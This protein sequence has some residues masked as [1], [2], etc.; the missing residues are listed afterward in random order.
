[1]FGKQG[2]IVR[3]AMI[4]Q[5]SLAA[6]TTGTGKP[7][8]TFSSNATGDS[9]GVRQARRT[10]EMTV[11]RWLKKRLVMLIA[12]YYSAAME[13]AINAFPDDEPDVTN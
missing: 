2:V 7:S 6:V 10:K 13:R 11:R 1:V 12:T 3:R 5:S 8:I 4:S 9:V